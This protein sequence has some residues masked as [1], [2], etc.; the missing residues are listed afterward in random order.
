[1]KGGFMVKP[2]NLLAYLTLGRMSFMMSA[3]ANQTRA[4]PAPMSIKT[5][6]S[7]KALP[8]QKRA[9]A[10]ENP[11][12]MTPPKA[13]MACP[14]ALKIALT[15]ETGSID[16]CLLSIPILIYVYLM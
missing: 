13:V 15:N 12:P 2:P 5:P 1:M 8:F 16:V 9:T 7:V 3:T 11:L 14:M 10:E 4:T 6:V